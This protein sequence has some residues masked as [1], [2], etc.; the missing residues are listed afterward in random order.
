MREKRTGRKYVQM[1]ERQPMSEVIKETL[2]KMKSVADTKTVIGD[3]IT[4]IDGVSII[5]VSRVAVGVG[6]GGGEYGARKDR[7]KTD[8]EKV[9]TDNFGGGGGTGIT[10][11]PVAFL[12]VTADGQAKLLNIGENTGYAGAAILGTVNGLDAAL[13][14][15]PDIIEK[16]K[17]LIK[18]KKSKNETCECEAHIVQEDVGKSEK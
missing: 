9:I 2:D 12:V 6:L 17:A 5:P 7:K 8:T 3:P 1:Q 16:I 4:L 11:T 13:D 10:V 18:G 15:A 14:K